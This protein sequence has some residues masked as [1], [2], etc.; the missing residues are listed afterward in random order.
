[1]KPSKR[2][3]PPILGATVY[4]P[5][6]DQADDA[7]GVTKIIPVGARGTVYSLDGTDKTGENY[8]SVVWPEQGVFTIYGESAI[9]RMIAKPK[10][11]GDEHPPEGSE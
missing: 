1:M 4:C 8:Y 5:K 10:T 11:Q 2:P 3:Q 9:R 7:D 6:P